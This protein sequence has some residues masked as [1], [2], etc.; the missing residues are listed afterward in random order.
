MHIRRTGEPRVVPSSTPGAADPSGTSGT[1]GTSSAATNAT[2]APSAHA[3]VDATEPTPRTV[4]ADF[5]ARPSRLATSGATQTAVPK[6]FDDWKTS[7][8]EATAREAARAEMMPEAQK[9]LEGAEKQKGSALTDDE[10]EWVLDAFFDQ[11]RPRFEALQATYVKEFER[12]PATRERTIQKAVVDER[13]RIQQLRDPFTPVA[14]KDPA[15]RAKEVVLWENAGAMV[16]VDLFAP[17]PKALVVPK[18]TVTTPMDAP[19]GLLDDIA[20]LA[21]H[22]SDAFMGVAGTPPAGI[23]VNPPQDLTVKQMHVHVMPDL[24][25]WL[26]F[27]GVP[28]QRP[29]R[30]AHVARDPQLAAQM[31]SFFAQLTA[32][33]EQKLGPST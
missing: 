1:A 6:L 21:A 11:E 8:V 26:S 31:Q 18:Q 13:A 12:T 17:L 16:L 15:A 27:L 20:L 25:D 28:A 14:Q 30:A 4:D 7:V 9:A 10:A 33:L 29:M 3:P 23:W 22:V 24:P 2:S 32:A 19:P 5:R